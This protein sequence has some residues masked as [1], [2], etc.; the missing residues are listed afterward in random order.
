MFYYNFVKILGVVLIFEVFMC[1]VVLEI[2]L[3]EI[4]YFVSIVIYIFVIRKIFIR[5]WRRRGVW[6]EGLFF[7][8]EII[9]MFGFKDIFFNEREG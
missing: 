3:V 6:D 2:L 8:I 4:V 9:G 1:V 7:V 5:G